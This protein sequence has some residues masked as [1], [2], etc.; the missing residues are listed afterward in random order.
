MDG[1]DLQPAPHKTARP[2]QKS[3]KSQSVLKNVVESMNEIFSQFWDTL[4]RLIGQIV[5]FDV[6]VEFSFASAATSRRA[7]GN[8]YFDRGFAL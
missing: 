4:P 8:L 2:G 6:C 3:S 7:G 1:L 5:G